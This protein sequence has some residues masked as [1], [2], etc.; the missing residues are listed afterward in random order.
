M[1]VFWLF[2]DGPAMPDV[3]N[4]VNLSVASAPPPKTCPRVGMRW[5]F[6]PKG[7]RSPKK[8]HRIQKSLD[9]ALE[10]GSDVEEEH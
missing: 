5:N 3:V 9:L 8:G 7:W 10:K 4:T 2:A 1:L 6:M